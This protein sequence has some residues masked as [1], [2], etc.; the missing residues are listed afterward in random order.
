MV[1]AMPAFFFFFF[2]SRIGIDRM[3]FGGHSGVIR[4]SGYIDAAE[5]VWLGQRR[6]RLCGKLARNVVCSAARSA[7]GRSE[8]RGFVNFGGYLQGAVYKWLHPYVVHWCIG[9]SRG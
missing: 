6:S 1:R 9:A 7:A 5:R 2:G 3:S 4:G 8:Q